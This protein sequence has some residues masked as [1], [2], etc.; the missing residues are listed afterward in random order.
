M[1]Q[2]EAALDRTM[3]AVFT[4]RRVVDKLLAIPGVQRHQMGDTEARMLFPAGDPACLRAVFS[5]I[6]PR[7]ILEGRVRPL[8]F[9]MN[10]RSARGGLMGQ[11]AVDG[12]D[13]V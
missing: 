3:L 7:G 13:A 2:G 8:H 1:G 11:R 4:S 9:P 6:R 10:W 12:N 5:V